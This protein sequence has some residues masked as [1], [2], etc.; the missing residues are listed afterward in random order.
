MNAL[1][2]GN[3]A[4]VVEET[5]QFIPLEVKDGITVG[6]I[7]KQDLIGRNEGCAAC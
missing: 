2:R 7:V 4:L 5:G 3:H 6:K 1:G